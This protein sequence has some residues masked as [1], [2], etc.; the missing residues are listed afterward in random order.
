M[1]EETSQSELPAATELK[2]YCLRC[3]RKL[4][5]P[6]AMMIGYGRICARKIA[7]QA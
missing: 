6:A 1:E 3:H 4:R 2:R 7:Q 5:N